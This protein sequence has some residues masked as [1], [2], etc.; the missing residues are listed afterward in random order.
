MKKNN[1]N[2]VKKNN[3]IIRKSL[4]NVQNLNNENKNISTNTISNENNI[5]KE[6]QMTFDKTEINENKNIL[7][8][9]DPQINL[10]DTKKKITCKKQNEVKEEIINI[11]DEENNKNNINNK[12]EDIKD[13]TKINL[14]LNKNIIYEKIIEENK[15]QNDINNKEINK[16]NQKNQINN[17]ISNNN[18][19]YLKDKSEQTIENSE[20]IPDDD[21][22]PK[23]TITCENIDS[24]SQQTSNLDTHSSSQLLDSEIQRDK[25]EHPRNLIGPQNNEVNAISKFNNFLTKKEPEDRYPLISNKEESKPDLNNNNHKL[26]ENYE[27]KPAIQYNIER[28]RPVFTLPNNQK[29]SISQEKPFH[30]INKYYDDNFILEDDEEIFFKNYYIY[31][32]EDSR[33]ASSDNGKKS[34]NKIISRNNSDEIENKENSIKKEE[35][36]NDKKSDLKDINIKENNMVDKNKEINKKINMNNEDINDIKIGIKERINIDEKLN[37]HKKEDE[38]K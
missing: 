9:E 8:N 38:I 10:N 18:N 23:D 25:Y 27:I 4:K 34:N 6:N 16:E 29:R 21:D 32:D 26:E 19:D 3:K 22:F 28:K 35:D 20:E 5:K 14:T 30:I 37:G 2:S 7:I 1:K 17:N 33:S 12:D 31:N 13:K 11:K 24:K 15:N 36:N